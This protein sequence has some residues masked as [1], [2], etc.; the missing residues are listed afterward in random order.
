M[1]HTTRPPGCPPWCAD[2]HDGDDPAAREHW[3]AAPAMPLSLAAP[4]DGTQPAL[5]VDLLLAGQ[6]ALIYLSDTVLGRV[7]TLAEAEQLHTELGE[8]LAAAQAGG[9]L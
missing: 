5:A 3:T 8:R 4:V 6:D 9:A 7:L 1:L 2:D